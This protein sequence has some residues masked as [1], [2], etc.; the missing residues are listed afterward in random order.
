MT[1]TNYIKREVKKVLK[2]V[3]QVQ[4][5]LESLIPLGDITPS[6]L[7]EYIYSCEE[8]FGWEGFVQALK[9]GGKN[10]DYI[11]NSCRNRIKKMYTPLNRYTTSSLLRRELK[12]TH[13]AFIRGEQTSRYLRLVLRAY[14]Q[15]ERKG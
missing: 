6:E 2:S 7:K 12:S 9:L 13:P 8:I 3:D 5:G 15:C 10:D 4:K 1:R 11:V 14:I